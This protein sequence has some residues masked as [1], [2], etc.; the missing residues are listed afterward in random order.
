[1]RRRDL[2][3]GL[4][5]APVAVTGAVG[6]RPR[7]LLTVMC[8]GGWD[9]TR[10]LDPKPVDGRAD[11]EDIE[12]LGGLV[13][14]TNR[15][16]RPVAATFFERWAPSCTAVNGIWVGTIGHSS[17]RARML[18]GTADRT[19]PDLPTLAGALLGS[20]TALGVVD[21]SGELEPGAL[22]PIAARMGRRQQ[23][24]GLLD[25]A[26]APPPP[27][28]SG[29]PFPAWEPHEAGEAAARAVLEARRRRLA[30]AR[31]SAAFDEMATARAALDAWREVADPASLP[32]ELLDFDGQLDL[33]VD[34]L[35]EGVSA[36]V[37][38]RMDGWDTHQDDARQD[39]Q[40]ESLFGSLDGV[41]DRLAAG[42]WL[43]EVLVWVVS[44]MG[45]N[46]V[47]NAEGGTDHWPLSSALLI[48]AGL[49]GAR[50]LGGTDDALGPLGVDRA[51][52]GTNAHAP[53]L[54]AADFLAG[55]YA[56]MG[57]DPGDPFPEADPLQA[58]SC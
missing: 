53:V 49:G 14:G 40:Y 46:P 43:D 29:R 6:G 26:L 41:L 24:A 44:E 56:A 39:D 25:P 20:D 28:G 34:L 22:G 27:A 1:M 15:T 33:A 51:H 2:L 47:L 52:G 18:H 11:G 10:C 4:G 57:G 58:L 3:A 5:V 9:V 50:V 38:V 8:D 35:T 42:G 21:L 7:R 16:L 45:R 17:C 37:L 32:N 13:V 30:A 54:A 31:P 23:V 19:R 48:G 36:S 55:L 12:V